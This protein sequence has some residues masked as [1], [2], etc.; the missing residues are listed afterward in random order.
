M[1]EGGEMRSFDDYDDDQNDDWVP[2][3]PM[4]KFKDLE[5]E[6]GSDREVIFLIRATK[7][8]ILSSDPTINNFQIV[9]IR[10]LFT[11][12]ID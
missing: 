2:K 1:S 7:R 3:E 6:E 9:F 4:I 5:D 11:V 8:N 12:L 10:F